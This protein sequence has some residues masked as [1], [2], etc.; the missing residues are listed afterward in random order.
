MLFYVFYSL[1]KASAF[2]V[3]EELGYCKPI[4]F[5]EAIG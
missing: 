5:A 1:K 2:A 3:V 4:L